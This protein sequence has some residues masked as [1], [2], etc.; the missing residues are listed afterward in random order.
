LSARRRAGRLVGTA[1]M[2]L[3]VKYD[4]ELQYK[5]GYSYLVLQRRAGG[6]LI[7]CK[8]CRRER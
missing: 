2:H 7:K 8:N 6:V 5:Q 4:G 1:A 3:G